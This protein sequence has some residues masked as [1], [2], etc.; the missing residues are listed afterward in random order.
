MD[1]NGQVFTV[2]QDYEPTSKGQAVD[3]TNV[4]NQI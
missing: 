1:L 3:E 4:K 2:T